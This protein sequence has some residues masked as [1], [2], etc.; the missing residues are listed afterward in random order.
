M[1]EMLIWVLVFVIPGAVLFRYRLKIFGPVFLYDAIRTAR[2][3]RHIV[4][5]CLFAVGLAGMLCWLYLAWFPSPEPI[6]GLGEL[7]QS[8]SLDAKDLPRFAESFFST[9]LI[10]QFTAVLLLT[11]VYTAGAITEE[12]ERGTLEYLLTTDL[13][14]QEIVLG[15]L[16]SR[17]ANMVLLILTGLPVLSFTQFLGGVDPNLVLASFAAT[18]ATMLS[19]GSLGILCSVNHRRTLTAISA[20][21]FWIVLFLI[22][23]WCVPWVNMAHPVFAY[24]HLE[25]ALQNQQL[26][27]AVFLYVGMH[28]LAAWLFCAW[29]MVR[30]RSYGLG[31]Q[32]F[33][34]V[35]VTAAPLPRTLEYV[36]FHRLKEKP[37]RIWDNPMLW[38]ETQVENQ[39]RLHLVY[40]AMVIIGLVGSAY[41]ATLWFFGIL[42]SSL[43]ESELG[44]ELMNLYIRIVGTTIACCL[45]VLIG[46]WSAG[47]ISRERDRQTLDGLLTT[48]LERSEILLAKFWGGILS[49]RWGMVA[50][51]IVWVGGLVTLGLHPLALFLLAGAWAA[52][53]SFTAC[54]GMWFSQV[55]SSTLQATFR[56]LLIIFILSMSPWVFRMTLGPGNNLLVRLLTGGM[57]PPMALANL[58]FAYT[59]E[60]R[61]K[62]FLLPA[63][64]G[65]ACYAG[66]AWILWRRVVARFARQ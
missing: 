63:L 58:A 25:E 23:C 50:L 35:K 14:N 55:S 44:S 30:L 47:T 37:R 20:T 18:G 39:Y 13:R 8:R 1:G 65:V 31:W 33:R 60:P 52:Y 61:Q 24:L 3:G 59:L 21:Y 4:L 9:Y 41:L 12:K 66:T 49:V 16:A 34:N 46:F 43:F 19:I 29:A 5:R 17:F 53:V 32:A 26:E 7:F 56:T 51:A 62:S 48:P 6:R 64:M 22:C 42:L 54:L 28:G 27:W 40:R 15:K 36:A 11:P 38:K 45:L 57:S 2:Q 10:V